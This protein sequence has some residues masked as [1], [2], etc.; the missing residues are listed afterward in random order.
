LGD[1]TVL[2][3][4][5]SEFIFEDF[6]AVSIGTVQTLYAIYILT[7]ERISRA[8]RKTGYFFVVHPV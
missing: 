1:V 8:K 6:M 3:E 4:I 7:P 5:N 2:W